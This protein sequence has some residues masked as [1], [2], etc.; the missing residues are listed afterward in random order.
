MESPARIAGC[1]R[2]QPAAL[3]ASSDDRGR[4]D[5]QRHRS[6]F[7]GLDGL[8]SS[9]GPVTTHRILTTAAEKFLDR[10]VVIDP[11]L[12]DHKL[13]TDYDVKSVPNTY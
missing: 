2:T 13:V 1:K 8:V 11:D 10:S 3:G 6:V 12:Y 4:A 5:A 9:A 7:C